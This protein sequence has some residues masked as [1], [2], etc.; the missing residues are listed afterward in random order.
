[1]RIEAGTDDVKNAAEAEVVANDL[2]ELAGMSFGGVGLRCEISHG[3]TRFFHAK[4]G[5]G[6]EPILLLRPRGTSSREEANEQ[7]CRQTTASQAQKH[8]FLRGT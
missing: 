5:A 7:K 3:D 8:Y 6:A 1:L 2:R 4:A